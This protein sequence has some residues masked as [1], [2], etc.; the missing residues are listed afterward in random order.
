MGAAV[1]VP[2]DDVSH[3]RTASQREDARED[4]LGPDP[5]QRRA[6]PPLGRRPACLA[7]CMWR[8]AHAP[9][10]PA[11]P[12]R[13]EAPEVEALAHDAS[14]AEIELVDGVL[15]DQQARGLKV[16]AVRLLTVDLSGSQLDHLSL[17]DGELQACNLANLRARRAELTRLT[18]AASR[19]TG[20]ALPE[21][22]LDDVTIRDSRVDLASFGQ[23]RLRR[24]TFEDCL[25]AE[26]DFLDAQLESV[27]FHRC[28]L[29]G[30]DFRGARLS[31]CEFRR[32]ELGAVHGVD[33]LRGSAMEWPD[34]LALAG[35]CAAALGIDVLD[36][37]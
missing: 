10:P 28:D 32:S 37:D 21:A 27:R 36:A 14:Y 12:G 31:R 13:L 30:A 9:Q 24:V 22:R 25:M 5:T 2:H 26:T 18:V 4:L 6:A 3:L 16:R 34:I 33:C 7:S 23:A 1:E 35:A 8:A 19:L 15:A 20:I 29:T 17:A 11:L